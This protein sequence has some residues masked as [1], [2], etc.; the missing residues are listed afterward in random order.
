MPFK[1]RWSQCTRKLIFGRDL[2]A[3]E[4][5]EMTFPVVNHIH[6]FAVICLAT[7]VGSVGG[8]QPKHVYGELL[9]NQELRKINPASIEC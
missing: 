8:G 4:Y 2:R 6:N 5:L 7:F 9:N 1:K 3:K